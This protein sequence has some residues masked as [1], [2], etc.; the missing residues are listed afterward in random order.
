MAS[1]LSVLN[2]AE[3]SLLAQQTGLGTTSNNV[4]NATTP[5]YVRQSTILADQSNGGQPGGVTVAGLQRDF[6]RFSFARVS[7]EGGLL[8]AATSRSN[9]LNDTQTILAPASSGIDTQISN[10]FAAAQA[11][12][13]NPSD[14][15]TRQ[16]FLTSASTLATG[17]STAAGNL[18]QQSTNLL[19]QAQGAASDLNQNLQQIAKLNGQIQQAQAS[20]GSPA[21]LQD[22]RDQLVQKVATAI[23][24]STVTDDQGHFTLLSSGVALVT[25]NVASTINVGTDTNGAMKI[26]TQS[27][28]G[29]PVDITSGVT[30]G[31]IGGL[32]EARDVDLKSAQSG[33]DQFAYDL[34]TT[35]NQVHASGY[36]SDGVTGRN[37]FTQP[38][39]VAGAAF[40]MALDPS[41]VGHPDRVAAAATQAELPGGNTN[42]LALAALSSA[43]LGVGTNDPTQRFDAVVAQVGAS[44]SQAT[45]DVSLRTATK[46]Q[47]TT[48]EQS[49]EGVNTDE[50]MVALSQYQAAFQASQK[51]MSV[52]NQLLGELMQ[53]L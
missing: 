27:P 32:R 22:Q 29:V 45:S 44:A 16:A 31:T 7:Q 26:T 18:Q 1:L 46:A 20:G 48:L 13:S 25:D 9:A 10:F 23:G 35:V 17:I 30:Q 15:S 52:T 49:N 21:E 14:T 41:M 42:A 19:T 51:V 8:G 2:I 34:S 6:D 3:S 50:E 33:L 47:A 12:T 5:G 24:A 37:L 28:G 38:T 39:Q 11:L 43:P 40:N 36:G 53:E 4:A